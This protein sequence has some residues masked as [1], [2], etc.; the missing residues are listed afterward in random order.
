MNTSMQW[1]E[2]AGRKVSQP[3]SEVNLN[4]ANN[5]AEPL[6]MSIQSATL[7]LLSDPCAN[8]RVALQSLELLYL[9][10]LPKTPVLE[11]QRSVRFV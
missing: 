6:S 11:S 1:Q 3:P 8:H 4:E 9:K 7:V 2:G 10:W 5:P